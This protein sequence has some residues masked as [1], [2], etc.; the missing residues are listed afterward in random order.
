MMLAALLLTVGGY[1]LCRDA[2]LPVADP[3]VAPLWTLLPPR[4]SPLHLLPQA[5][6]PVGQISALQT[7]KQH[8]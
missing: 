5:D 2:P 1:N 7:V 4:A 6:T 3:T 8:R